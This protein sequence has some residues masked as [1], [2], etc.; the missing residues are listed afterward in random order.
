MTAAAY[1]NSIPRFITGLETLS[2]LLSKAESAGKLNG[3]L[4]TL[5]LIDDMKGLPFQIQACCNTVTKTV[6][7]VGGS[8][9]PDTKF[10]DVEITC[11]EVQNCLF[12]VIRWVT[13]NGTPEVFAGRDENLIDFQLGDVRFKLPVQDYVSRFAVPNFY[14]HFVTAYDILRANGV[15]IGKRDYLENFLGPFIVSQ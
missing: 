1:N 3:D 14:F 12:K 9:L 8:A 10:P 6:E 4:T 11:A 7:R 13:E 2:A 15:D 5:K